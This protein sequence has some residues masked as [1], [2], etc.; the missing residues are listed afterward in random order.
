MAFEWIDF[1]RERWPTE[2][3]LAASAVGAFLLGR[4]VFGRGFLM[5]PLCGVAGGALL[6]RAVTNQPLRRSVDEGSRTAGEWAELAG[7]AGRRAKGAVSEQ[8]ERFAGEIRR[9]AERTR[10]AGETNGT[11]FPSTAAKRE[12]GGPVSASPKREEPTDD[13]Q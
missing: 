8:V 4:A 6:A 1:T 5:R 2:T 11:E 12:P 9:A 10:S 13:G 7:E 3:R